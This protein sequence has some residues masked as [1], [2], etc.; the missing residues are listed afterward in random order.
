MSFRERLDSMLPPVTAEGFG[1]KERAVR[2]A[3]AF[4]YA[5]GAYAALELAS[6]DPQIM[7]ASKRR[8]IEVGDELRARAME[9]K[10]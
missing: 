10:P 1:K 7:A 3:I 9:V 8:W 4:A 5:C 6:R 2:E